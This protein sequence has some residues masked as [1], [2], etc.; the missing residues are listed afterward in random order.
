MKLKTLI[1]LLLL[2]GVGYAF[3]GY[4]T[5]HFSQPALAY[6]RY[7]SALI[8]GDSARVKNIIATDQP[9]RAFTVHDARMQRLGGE[10]RLMWYEFLSRK[11]SF[12]FTREIILL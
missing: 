7:A 2:A 5:T 1:L 9:L 4:A 11:L 12:P 10:P 8:D 3:Y 6:K